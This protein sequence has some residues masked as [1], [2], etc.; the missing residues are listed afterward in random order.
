[1][2][3]SFDDYEGITDETKKVLIKNGITGL[4]P[5]QA[6]TFES[7]YTKKDVIARDLTGTGKTLAFCLPLVERLRKQE[8]LGWGRKT[9]AIILA[10]TREL[11]IQVSNELEKLKH[12]RNEF[13]VAL[14]Y[15]GVSIERQE[16]ALK[17]GVEFIVGTTGRTIDHIKRG[18]TDLSHIETVI[19]DE[20][21]RMLDMGFQQDIEQ[22]MQE[23][24]KQGESKPQ[25]ILFSATVPPW[26]QNVAKNHL[27][28]EFKFV[29]LVKDLKN[30]TSKTVEHIAIPCDDQR[31]IDA[32]ADLLKLHSKPDNKIIVFVQ[33]KVQAHQIITSKNL[34]SGAG[35]VDSLN[36]Q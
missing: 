20:A 7:I 33:T 2:G 3:E 16:N 17:N 14:I 12:D 10:P 21:D 28:K 24:G 36:L 18:N 8:A 31:K 29:D 6:A 19:L 15:G 27:D 25:F 32:L 35:N 26:V 5:I 30:K 23:V 4:F 11:A 22:I 1:M 9:R 13:K 34:K